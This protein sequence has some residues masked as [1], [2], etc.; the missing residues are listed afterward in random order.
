M[1]FML[2]FM[3]LQFS[4]ITFYGLLISLSFRVRVG[5]QLQCGD[6]NILLLGLGT[7]RSTK[8]RLLFEL[9]SVMEGSMGSSSKHLN[10]EDEAIKLLKQTKVMKR[11]NF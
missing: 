9:Y 2:H 8:N 4:T 10:D 5:L 1:L 3:F 6:K 11:D 7:G